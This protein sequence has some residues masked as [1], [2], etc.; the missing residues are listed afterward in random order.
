M[1]Q[2][3][4][5]DASSFGITFFAITILATITMNE[6]H[7]LI[8]KYIEGVVRGYTHSAIIAG[9]P[10]TG[11]TEAVLSAMKEMGLKEKY[12]YFYSNNYIS[13]ME[14][15]LLLRDV[16]LLPGKKILILDDVEETLKQSR[17][18]SLMKGALWE[19]GGVRRVTWNSGRVKDKE[20]D[21]EGGVVFLLNELNEKNKLFQ[22]IRD[23]GW[24]YIIKLDKKEKINLLRERSK[25]DY[26]N[27]PLK[28]RE[29]IVNLIEREGQDF[30]LR[31]LQKAYS[32]YLLSPNHYQNLI[33]SL[34]KQDPKKL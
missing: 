4:F 30:S 18:L 16:N 25:K 2:K 6:K 28:V 31:I 5:L 20:F 8:K 11:K 10:G 33:V 1:F 27:V 12:D 15:Y 9:E 3:K 29:K 19:A 34:L 17:A 7:K 13:P 14:L 26:P 21:F 22:A 24:F 23:R 32:L